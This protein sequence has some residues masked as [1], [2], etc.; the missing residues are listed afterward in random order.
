MPLALITQLV[1]DKLRSAALGDLAPPDVRDR[2]VAQALLQYGLDVP[3]VQQADALAMGANVALPVGWIT[4]RSVLDALEYPVGL[5]PMATL[6]AVPTKVLSGEWR[7]VLLSDTLPDNSP[8]RVHF[9]VPHAVDGST[10]PAEHINA[11]ACWAAAEM[12]RQAATKAGHDRDATI[13]AAAVNGSS[14]SG[15]L[16]RRAKDWA[17]QYRTALGLPD[18]EARTGGEAAG[19]VVSWGGDGHRRGR[20]ASL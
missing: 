13:N 12:C 2:A 7:L 14:Q 16:G 19:T 3:L 17:A 5:A 6:P 8:V 11:V 18:P 20:F 15:D 4:G 9:T 1:D 10:V